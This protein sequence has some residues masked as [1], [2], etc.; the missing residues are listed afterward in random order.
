[1]HVY[2]TNS[3]EAVAHWRVPGCSQAAAS[4]SGRCSFGHT[5]DGNFICV[6]ECRCVNCLSPTPHP[7][8]P[9]HTHTHTHTP[10]HPPKMALRFV[11]IK[12]SPVYV[13]SVM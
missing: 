1:M 5:R 2:D 8:A 12:D 11:V 10:S 7:P 13:S 4:Y 3:W 6:G 9:T